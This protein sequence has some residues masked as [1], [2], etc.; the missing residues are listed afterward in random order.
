MVSTRGLPTG[1]IAGVLLLVAGAL[2]L[3][4]G[5]GG[6]DA[7]ERGLNPEHPAYGMYRRFCAD[8][9][10][11]RADGQGPSAARLAKPPPDL[12]GLRAR[13]G[14]RLRL[15]WLA[16]VIDGRRTIRAHERDGMPIWGEELVPDQPDF[17]MRERARH[18]LV[19]SLADYVMSIQREP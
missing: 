13:Y 16:H 10:G 4:G 14:D 12:T 17:Q 6:E 9:H 18:R 2:L 3:A 8:C 5:T 15:D 1:P 7:P 11:L 19:H